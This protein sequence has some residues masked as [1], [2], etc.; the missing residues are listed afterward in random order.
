MEFDIFAMMQEEQNKKQGKE[1]TKQ[2][3]LPSNDIKV[4][5]D[6]EKTPKTEDLDGKKKSKK[7]SSKKKEQSA[8][9]VMTFDEQLESQKNKQVMAIIEHLL[10]LDG[11]REKME[12]PNVSIDGM[13]DYIKKEAQKQAVNGCAMI[14]DEVVYG[15]GRHYYDEDGKVAK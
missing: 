2:V 11:M 8:K 13:Y 5:E 7:D 3:D 1:L 10:S 4:A 9:K 14:E 6:K 12:S 15:W